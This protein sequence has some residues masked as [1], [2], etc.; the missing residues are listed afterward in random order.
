MWESSA[1]EPVDAE[2]C[3][4]RED[5]VTVGSKV[6]KGYYREL[7]KSEQNKSVILPEPQGAGTKHTLFPMTT[8][9]GSQKW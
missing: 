6:L 2:D 9:E 4:Q 3:S 8:E 1:C 7:D 5:K